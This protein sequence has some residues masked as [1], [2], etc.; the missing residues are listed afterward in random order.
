MC[1][2]V[3]AAVLAATLDQTHLGA[4][5]A[6][7]DITPLLVLVFPHAQVGAQVVH[8]ILPG[9]ATHDL[10]R[11]LV[12]VLLCHIVA[13]LGVDVVGHAVDALGIGSG[14]PL[15]HVTGHVIQA[16]VVGLIGAHGSRDDAR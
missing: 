5:A 1:G 12:G 6:E 2:L 10:A 16:V 8:H 7:S 11:H 4:D 15:A 9:T 13:V 14:G 3:L